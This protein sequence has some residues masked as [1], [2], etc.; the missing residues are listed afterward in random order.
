MPWKEI[1][2]RL[3][4]LP[5]FV[6]V[7]EKRM[8]PPGMESAYNIY[9]DAEQAQAE[10]L[11]AQ[12]KFPDIGLRLVVVGLGFALE[13]PAARV[14]ASAAD[15]KLARSLPGGSD[16]DWDGASAKWAESAVGNGS[17]SVPLFGSFGLQQRDP[18]G[19]RDLV[20]P[21]FLSCADAE[22]VLAQV[23]QQSGRSAGVLRATSV[24]EM[25]R[26]MNK[27]ELSDPGKMRFVAP[28]ASLRFCRAMDE[29]EEQ[30]Q[31]QAAGATGADGDEEGVREENY[32]EG[33]R[34]LAGD[35]RDAAAAA[36]QAAARRALTTLFDGDR[37]SRPAQDA[38]L[39]PE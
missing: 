37:I 30:Q 14:V 17:P 2:D 39:F 29:A 32:A 13:R 25:A 35:L 26:M 11:E 24:Q 5:C 8:P 6:I 36:N 22:L 4:N 21:L 15:V 18:E 12:S 16:I 3:D 38:G 23:E 9:V 10:L 28:S 20:T 33:D 1:T 7:D 34:G 31:Q 19:V 27:G